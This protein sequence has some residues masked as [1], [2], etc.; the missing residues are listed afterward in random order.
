MIIKPKKDFVSS[1]VWGAGA[2]S[3]GYAASKIVASA[4][5]KKIDKL[6]RTK[7]KV[8]VNKKLYRSS[9]ANVNVNYRIYNAT[10]PKGVVVMLF[11]NTKG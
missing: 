9:Q 5:V 4:K 7:R 1:A 10:S 6:S 11:C 3:I 2:N 8:Y